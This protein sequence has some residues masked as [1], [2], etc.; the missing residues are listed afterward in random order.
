MTKLKNKI[1]FSSI[2][3]YN[4]FLIFKSINIYT[5]DWH[6]LSNLREF[7][8]AEAALLK[9]FKRFWGLL[10]NGKC[11]EARET[12][13][14]HCITNECMNEN[15]FFRWNSAPILIA[16]KKCWSVWME[17]FLIRISRYWFFMPRIALPTG[18]PILMAALPPLIALS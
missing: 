13:F 18:G 7:V 15:S 11:G 10:W 9:W 5:T 2:F 4:Y 12:E 8:T 16:H 3:F 17:A 6:D 1:N 14:S